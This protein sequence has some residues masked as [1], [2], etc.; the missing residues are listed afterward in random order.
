MAW[1]D[2]CKRSEL[3]EGE[4][5]FVDLGEHQLAVFLK[6]DRKSVV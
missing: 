1:M 6:E 4:G 5:K 3:T 2:L